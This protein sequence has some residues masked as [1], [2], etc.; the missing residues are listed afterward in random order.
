MWDND[1][2]NDEQRDMLSSSYSDYDIDQLGSMYEAAG[3]NSEDA[4]WSMI[5]DRWDDEY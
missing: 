4:M 5:H 2:F 1:Y 3:M